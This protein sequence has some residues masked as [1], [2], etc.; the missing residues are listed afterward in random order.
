MTTM[1]ADDG[2]KGRKEARFG[3]DEKFRWFALVSALLRAT[4]R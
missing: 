2:G 4:R 3:G 1:M